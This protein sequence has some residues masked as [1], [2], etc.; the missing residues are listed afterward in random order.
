MQIKLN[1]IKVTKRNNYVIHT[2]KT[3]LSG[4]QLSG[5]FTYPDTCFG[6]NPNYISGK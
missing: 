5:L 1:Y 4:P 3:H 2:V 6:T